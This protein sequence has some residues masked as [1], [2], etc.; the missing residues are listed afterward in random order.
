MLISFHLLGADACPLQMRDRCRCACA[1]WDC[2]GTS[3][4][5]CLGKLACG[6]VWDGYRSA[7]KSCSRVSGV[8]RS[9]TA[10]ASTG[11]VRTFSTSR[12]PILWSQVGQLSLKSRRSLTFSLSK[13]TRLWFGKEESAW[14]DVE[15]RARCGWGSV[16]ELQQETGTVGAPSEGVTAKLVEWG[17]GVYSHCQAT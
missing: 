10:L 12:L 17:D 16:W 13:L 2:R 1:G 14:W 6:L 8:K 15:G 9:P 3:L 7:C 5:K 11:Y 4:H